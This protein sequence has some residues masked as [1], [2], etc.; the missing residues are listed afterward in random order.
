MNFILKIAMTSVIIAG[1]SEIAK[2]FTL[3]ASI[4][5]SLPLTS[6]LAM[7]W[8]YR[9]TGDVQKIIDLSHGIFWAVLPSLIFFLILPLL[10]KS[11]VKFGMAMLISSAVMFVAYTIYV[12]ILNK[13]GLKI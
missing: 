10:L 5:A 11:G 6:V 2:R 9:D 12:L 8:L 4:I 3:F 7:I 13:L 1:V